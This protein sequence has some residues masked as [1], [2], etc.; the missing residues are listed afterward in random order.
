MSVWKREW[1]LVCPKQLL[2]WI[3]KDL[4][5][6]VIFFPPVVVHRAD[7]DLESPKRYGSGVQRNCQVAVAYGLAEHAVLSAA[8]L[9]QSPVEVAIARLAVREVLLPPVVVLSIVSASSVPVDEGVRGELEAN[10][11]AL[12][13][14]RCRAFANHMTWKVP[15]VITPAPAPMLQG[16]GLLGQFAAPPAPVSFLEPP[17]P[18][19]GAM[20]LPAQ[21]Y[22]MQIPPNVYQQE[23]DSE[24]RGGFHDP[25][26][27]M[28]NFGPPIGYAGG[29]EGGAGGPVYPDL[30]M[31]AQQQPLFPMPAL[32]VLDMGGTA[33]VHPGVGAGAGAGAQ[34]MQR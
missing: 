29:A 22:F 24:S 15:I 9:Q 21:T 32:P 8:G 28:N 13:G 5:Q 2:H 16:M 34:Q 19:L 18:L 23:T 3:Q 26:E 12:N 6:Q 4:A 30:G 7:D 10:P 33:K 14:L 11:P 25:Q 27:D 1:D 17:P 20:V 31:Y